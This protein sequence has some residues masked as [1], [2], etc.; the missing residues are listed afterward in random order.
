MFNNDV[1]KLNASVI[2]IIESTY[3]DMTNT[4][5]IIANYFIDNTSQ[6][7]DFSASSISEKLHVSEASLT[8]F[9]KKCGYSGYREFIYAYR[10]NIPK[11][12]QFEDQVTKR[13]LSNYE[14]TLEKTYSLIDEKKIKHIAHSVIKAERIYFYGIGSSGLVA[15]EM[16]S[17]SMRLGLNCDAFTDPDLMKMN[18]ALLDENCIVIALSLSSESSVIFEALEKAS[19]NHA[20]TVLF[21]ANVREPFKDIC[22][23]VVAVANKEYLNYGNKITPQFP[24]LVMIDI[25]YSYLLELDYNSPR[26]KFISTLEALNKIEE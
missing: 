2:P 19:Q 3:N 16:K 13:V 18:S 7:E 12:F 8:R 23:E 5:K 10:E 6:Q 4:E 17:R 26:N 15:L 24:L 11:D 21:T 22:D 25:L 14:E 9:A 1:E 20:K